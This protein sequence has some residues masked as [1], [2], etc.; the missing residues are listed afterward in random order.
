MKHEPSPLLGLPF[1]LRFWGAKGTFHHLIALFCTVA[2]KARQPI[3]ESTKFCNEINDLAPYLKAKIKWNPL[4]I[5]YLDAG[6]QVIHEGL[7]QTAHH[8]HKM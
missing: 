8:R 2:G 4:L 3:G 1:R 7:A 5:K 6:M